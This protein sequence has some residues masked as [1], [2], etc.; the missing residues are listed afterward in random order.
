MLT[1]LLPGVEMMAAGAGDCQEWWPVRESAAGSLYQRCR[2]GTG[3]PE[4]MISTRFSASPGQ[5]HA[6]V[7]DYDRFAGFIPNVRVSRVL[8]RAAD[9]SQLV[10]HQLDFPPPVA[11]RIYVIRSR[12]SAS[13]PIDGYYR[14]EWELANGIFPALQDDAGVRP[15][16]FSGFWELASQDGGLTTDARYTVFSDPG[17]LVPAWLVAR[18]T[19]LYVEEVVEAIRERLGHAHVAR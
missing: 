17:G 3:L 10:F 8:E 2:V 12:D 13:R 6:L 5:V 4:V 11:D 7:T 1:V 9:G 16:A 19:G 15:V 14:V 18:M